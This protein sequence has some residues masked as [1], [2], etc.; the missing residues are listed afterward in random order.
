M[1]GKALIINVSKETFHIEE[2]KDEILGPISWGLYCHLEKYRSYQYPIFDEH[3]VLCFGAGLLSWSEISGTRRLV[4]TFRSPL[5]GGF[6]LSSMGGAAYVFRYLGVDYAAIEG[7]AKEPTIILIKSEPSGEIKIRFEHLTDEKLVEVFKKYRGT[8]GAFALAYY[9][10]DNYSDFYD[11]VPVRVI[12]IGPAS[13]YTRNGALVSYASRDF[14]FKGKS[15]EYSCLLY[16][17]PS[18]RD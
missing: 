17:S 16:T 6:F 1:V 7:K 2:T 15:I 14:N 9:I 4:F 10:A 18:P 8:C 5:W 12:T 11:K 13:I 3:N